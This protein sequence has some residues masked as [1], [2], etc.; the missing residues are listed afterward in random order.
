MLDLVKRVTLAWAPEIIP[1]RGVSGRYPLR[2]SPTGR[3]SERNDEGTGMA[4]AA[5]RQSGKDGLAFFF[6]RIHPEVD[7]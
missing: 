2:S 3:E 7:I 5:F 4:Q 6:A 1:R